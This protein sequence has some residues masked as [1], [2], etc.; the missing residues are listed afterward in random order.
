[1]HA[2]TE[3]SS[4]GQTYTASGPS[5]HPGLTAHTYPHIHHMCWLQRNSHRC[6]SAPSLPTSVF[7]TCFPPPSL[8]QGFLFPPLCP[9]LSPAGKVFLPIKGQTSITTSMKLTL[10]LRHRA[11]HTDPLGT[12]PILYKPS[13]AHTLNYM[14]FCQVFPPPKQIMRLVELYSVYLS[15]LK[16]QIK[17]S[18]TQRV[19]RLSIPL[20]FK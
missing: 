15:I 4:T 7:Y 14:Y 9:L 12:Q 17:V 6:P 10:I 8:L 13:S 5:G 1:M 11:S 18:D 2:G 20:Y 3:D 16:P 19:F